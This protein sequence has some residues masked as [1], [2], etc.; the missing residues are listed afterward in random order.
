MYAYDQAYSSSNNLQLRVS[1]YSELVS[2]LSSLPN[3]VDNVYLYLHSDYDKELQQYCFVFYN[4]KYF[5]ADD[6]IADIPALKIEGNVYLFS[7]HGANLAPSLSQATNRTV[8]AS[9]EG[10]SFELGYACGGVKDR[11][12]RLKL[13]WPRRGWWAFTPDGECEHYTKARYC[14]GG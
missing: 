4:G 7:C 11:I 9:Y 14:T 8:I 1:S 3:H 12:V 13:F 5:G 2:A 10:V 6:I